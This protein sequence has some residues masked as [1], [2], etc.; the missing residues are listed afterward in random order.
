MGMLLLGF[1]NVR[2]VMTLSKKRKKKS[3]YLRIKGD[4]KKSFVLHKP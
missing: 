3:G 2:W 4:I 1:R